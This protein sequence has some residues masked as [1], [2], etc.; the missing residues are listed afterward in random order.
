MIIVKLQ[1]DIFFAGALK[2]WKENLNMTFLWCDAGEKV[3]KYPKQDLEW[4]RIENG[5]ILSYQWP[6]NLS[7]YSKGYS[8]G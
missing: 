8:P 7:F 2:F 1:W 6:I 5:E 4:E 3:F